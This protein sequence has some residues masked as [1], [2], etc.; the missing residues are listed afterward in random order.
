LDLAPIGAGFDTYNSIPMSLTVSQCVQHVQHT[1]AGDLSAEIDSLSIINQSGEFLVSMHPW[2]WLERSPQKLD[3]RGTVTVSGASWNEQNFK[4]TKDVGFSDYTFLEGDEFEV[5]SGTN[6]NKDFYS[7]VKRV[8]D[9]TIVLDRSISDGG[10]VSAVSGSIDTSA[11]SLPS[12]LM[13]V[14]AYE[15]SNS[16]TNSFEFTSLQKL[17]NSRTNQIELTNWGYLGAIVHGSNRDTGG[18]PVPRL[19]IWPTPSSNDLAA[20]TIFYRAGWEKMTG[21]T[22]I[23]EIPEW[24]ESFF[25]QLVRSFARGYEEEDASSMSERLA[26]ASMS[27]LFISSIRRDSAIQPDLGP[28]QGGHVQV[29]PKSPNRFLRSTVSNPS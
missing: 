17:I 24:M 15:T 4:F 3:L 12:D 27:P 13:E 7:I 23:V 26:E 21:D 8:D 9:S 6:V 22:D 20:L 29:M 1:L 18:K 14:I 5:T 25:I 28:Q 10:L 2:K 19:E 16:L 11:V